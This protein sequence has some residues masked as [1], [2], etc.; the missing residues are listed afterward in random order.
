VRQGR[1]ERMARRE[2]GAHQEDDWQR[3]CN[4]KPEGHA[5]RMSGGGNA[6]TSRTRGT[7]GH[8]ATRGNGVMICG[9]AGRWE[10]VASLEAM[11]QPATQEER[12][13]MAQREAMAG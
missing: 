5:E 8:G 7:G 12:E 2:A 9:D 1:A 11:Q 3:W 10:V 4:N 13:A 6:T